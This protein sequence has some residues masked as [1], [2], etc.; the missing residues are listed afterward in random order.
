MEET[1]QETTQETRSFEEALARLEQIAG[2][3]NNGRAP[4][5]EA[6]TLFE[7]GA[8]LLRFCNQALDNA[9]QTV[10]LVLNNGENGSPNLQEMPTEEKPS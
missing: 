4:L 9:E 8:S 3:L 6:L 1:T 5:A 2:S 7:E 10:N